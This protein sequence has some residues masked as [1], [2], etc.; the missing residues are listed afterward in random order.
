M[1][2]WE[3]LKERDCLANVEKMGGQCFSDL[4]EIEE[5]VRVWVHQGQERPIG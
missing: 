3:N 5:G 1:I 2:W 4:K